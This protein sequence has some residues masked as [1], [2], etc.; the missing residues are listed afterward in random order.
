MA[1]PRFGNL[2][3]KQNQPKTRLKV[4]C[5]R[6]LAASLFSL[7]EYLVH[8]L[9]I[10]RKKTGFAASVSDRKIVCHVLDIP[11]ALLKEMELRVIFCAPAASAPPAVALRISLDYFCP[12]FC[13]Q[14][15]S[16][17]C[18][19]RQRLFLAVQICLKDES[20]G[21]LRAAAEKHCR[22]W[23]ILN[24]IQYRE[25]ARRIPEDSLFFQETHFEMQVREIFC[26]YGGP[27]LF[28]PSLN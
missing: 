15:K 18:I 16:P 13:G 22:S 27:G 11:Q 1:K 6:T 20:E 28:P 19:R 26:L 5:L 8:Y 21:K 14:I 23:I 2:T 10:S 4:A 17:N 7:R 12:A 3:A 9:Q 25:L 24:R